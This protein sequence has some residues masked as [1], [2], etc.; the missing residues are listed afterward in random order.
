MRQ[1]K[2][3]IFGFVFIFGLL[4]LIIVDVLNIDLLISISIHQEYGWE[5]GSELF[6]QFLYNWGPSPSLIGTVVCLI[7]IILIKLKFIK[8]NL[9]IHYLMFPFLTLIAGP[10]IFVNLIGKE[11]WGRPRP[12]NCIELGGTKKFQSVL[13]INPK[14]RISLSLLDM[15]HPDFTCVPWH[16]YSRANG[17]FYPFAFFNWGTLVSLGRILQGGH[18]LSDVIGSLFIVTLVAVV[19]IPS[20][21]QTNN[22][23]ILM[24]TKTDFSLVIPFFNEEENVIPVLK[25]AINACPGAEIIAVDDG[26]S[27]KTLEKINTFKQITV[28]SFEENQG[29]SSA[30][31]AGMLHAKNDLICTMDG[32][33]QNNPHDI[34]NLIS[35]WKKETVVCGYRVNRQ[36]SLSKKISSKIGN[37]IRNFIIKDGIRDTG[38]SLKLFPRDTIQYLPHFNGIHR[39]FPA[40][41]KQAGFKLIEVP[42]SHRPRSL[43]VSK[44]NNVGRAKRGLWDLIGVFWLLKR[45]IRTNKIQ[46]NE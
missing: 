11:M 2:F 12:V 3:L 18:F 15:P 26:S 42:V 14:R 43:G 36:D 46:I 27:D 7:L 5:K 45:Q 1:N 4:S 8:L 13:E 31:I 30:M 6:W 22:F 39:F 17:N 10:G 34:K 32:D 23:I 44:Y 21:T 37:F 28:L 29:Q 33:G 38:C 19:F 25:E 9:P 35:S 40:F 24:D 20:F 41:C 16:S